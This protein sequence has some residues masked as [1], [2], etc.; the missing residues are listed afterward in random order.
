MI[1]K[2]IEV[3][4]HGEGLGGIN[5]GKFAVCRFE[6]HEWMK[7]SAISPEFPLLAGRGWTRDHVL[8]LDI[9]TGEGAIFKPG[10]LAEYD[11]NEKHKIWVCPMYQPFLEWLYKQDLKD[12]SKLPSLVTFTEEQAP[13]AFSG[14]RRK[15]GP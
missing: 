9:Q 10:G 8:V 14:Y 7:K 11:L 4:N 12:L 3:T 5:H 15:G 2:F 13:S 1:V 6:E